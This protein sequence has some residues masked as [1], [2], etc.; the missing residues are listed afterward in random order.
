LSWEGIRAL[1]TQPGVPPVSRRD[2]RKWSA[3]GALV[4]W[5][6]YAVFLSV[7]KANPHWRPD[8]IVQERIADVAHPL[9]RHLP[10][11]RGL[12]AVLAHLGAAEVMVPVLIAMALL[13]FLWRWTLLPT[14]ML[15]AAYTIVVVTVTVTKPRLHRPEPYDAP[16]ELGRAFPSGH[17]A[18]A[19]M[20]WMG[21]ALCL[22]L[23][24]A[25]SVRRYTKW[26]V[27]WALL[28]VGV[29]HVAMLGRSA[30]WW[31]DLIGGDF[32]GLACLS[33]LVLAFSL[34]GLVGTLDPPC[35]APNDE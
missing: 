35:P 20:V 9:G 1:F 5:L 2:A 3:I 8:T 7:A 31:T 22:W 26:A 21:F 11:T 32:A 18:S 4:G 24:G 19:L 17:T 28:V 16:G 6:G 33:T 29:V 10:W 30:H 13:F 14:F 12:S 25:P 34:V 15:G 23:W 27:A